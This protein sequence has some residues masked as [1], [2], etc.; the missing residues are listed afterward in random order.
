MQVKKDTDSIME[1]FSGTLWEAEMIR[2]L[3]K[4]SNIE[5]FLK[6]NVINTYLYD[7]IIADGVKVM[8]S[9]SAYNNSKEIVDAYYKN[10]NDTP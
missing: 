1:I 8:T 5:S 10:L 6:N 3:L 7:P 9:R 2:T 4:N